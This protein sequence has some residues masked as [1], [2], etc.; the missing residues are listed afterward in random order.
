MRLSGR[1]PV[2]REALT[3]KSSRQPAGK[4]HRLTNHP[5]PVFFGQGVNVWQ[6]Q[7]LCQGRM[8][9][10]FFQYAMAWRSLKKYICQVN[11][12][13]PCRPR[14]ID[15]ARAQHDQW[16]QRGQWHGQRGQWHGSAWI[17]SAATRPDMVQ[18]LP[19]DR[20]WQQ[21]HPVVPFAACTI[22][23]THDPPPSSYRACCRIISCAAARK[24]RLGKIHSSWLQRWR[25]RFVS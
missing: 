3:S 25:T 4:K 7:A 11:S 15:G 21:C 20:S 13:D 16:R 5:I 17:P 1:G 10:G 6:R 2:Q 9:C 22:I 23:S 12:L 24:N 18:P 14:K 19:P 8:P